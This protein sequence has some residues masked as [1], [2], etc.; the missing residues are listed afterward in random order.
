MTEPLTTG[1]VT[2][3]TVTGWELVASAF[4]GFI[5]PIDYSI[6]LAHLLAASVL[7]SRLQI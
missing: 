6:V 7:L 5:T 3:S 4:I 1:S 2:A